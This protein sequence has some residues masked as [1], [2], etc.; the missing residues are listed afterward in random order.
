[1]SEFSELLSQHI[2]NKNIKTY[3]LAQYCG[4]DRSNMYKI[5]KGQR[6]PTSI[7]MVANMCRFMQLSP[8]ETKEMQEAY[9]ITLIGPE[10]YYRRKNTKLFFEEFRLPSLP[11]PTA[12]YKAEIIPEKDNI[13]LL[14]TQ[15]EI[16]NALLRIL[17]LEFSREKGHIRMLI[18]PDY[19]FLVDLLV[20][21][22][23]CKGVF[24]FN[25]YVSSVIVVEGAPLLMKMFSCNFHSSSSSSGSIQ[26]LSST[27]FTI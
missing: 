13:F 1:M 20:T 27:I 10:N 23:P 21:N 15:T 26:F 3:P 11:F 25:L 14:N 5:I 2:H 22:V 19:S 9:M 18:Q 7:E 4:L 16:N 24:N 12:T 6:K 17:S 8:N